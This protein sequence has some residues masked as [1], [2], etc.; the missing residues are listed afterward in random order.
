V[1]ESFEPVKLL[2]HW[3]RTRSL[4][5][6]SRMIRNRDPRSDRQA[7][8]D[9]RTISPTYVEMTELVQFSGWSHKDDSITQINRSTGRIRG[10]AWGGL[11]LRMRR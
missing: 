7:N 11:E 5:A 3:K 8:R 6:P 2:Q 4:F 10:S 9:P 1:K